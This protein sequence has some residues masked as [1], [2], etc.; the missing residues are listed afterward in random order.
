MSMSGMFLPTECNQILTH[1]NI[2]SKSS[3]I[4]KLGQH[5]S[6][7]KRFEKNDRQEICS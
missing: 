7:L 2:L 5:V 1:E 6:V 4:L 3:C